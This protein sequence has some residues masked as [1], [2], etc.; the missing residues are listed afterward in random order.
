MMKLQMLKDSSGEK[1]STN[2]ETLLKD[3]MIV[4]ISHFNKDSGSEVVI[5]KM[6]QSIHV[7]HDALKEI[8]R[9]SL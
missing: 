9:N 8:Q 2:K 5:P 1:S 6:D 4:E 3:L 7:F